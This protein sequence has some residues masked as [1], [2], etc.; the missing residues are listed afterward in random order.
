MR[1]RDVC[2]QEYSLSGATALQGPRPSRSGRQFILHIH[3][4]SVWCGR[5]AGTTVLPLWRA[6][7]HP[8]TQ[9]KSATW[10]YGPCTMVN[11]STPVKA[12]TVR[13][14]FP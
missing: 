3:V 7:A 5:Q 2:L 10:K 4:R 11:G 14:R 8:Y 1:T 6:P 13:L 12:L 9:C